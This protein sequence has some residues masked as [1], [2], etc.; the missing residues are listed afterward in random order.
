MVFLS[1]SF[2]NTLKSVALGI[3]WICQTDLTNAILL[4]FSR[5][6]RN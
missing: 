2:P 5:Y 6:K 3:G 4:F 1:V